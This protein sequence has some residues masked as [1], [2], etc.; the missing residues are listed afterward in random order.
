M[1][2]SQYSISTSSTISEALT[3]T[4]VLPCRGMNSSARAA[5]TS[6]SVR[7]GR[8]SKCSFVKPTELSS[9]QALSVMRSQAISLPRQQAMTSMLGA[10]AMSLAGTRPQL[11]WRIMYPANISLVQVTH[12]KSLFRVP[13]ANAPELWSVIA[14]FAGREIGDAPVALREHHAYGD[15]ENRS[16]VSDA[17]V[18]AVEQGTQPEEGEE[19]L[20]HRDKVHYL[21]CGVVVAGFSRHDRIVHGQAL[22]VR[23]GPLYQPVARIQGLPGFEVRLLIDYFVGI[24]LFIHGQP[25][26]FRIYKALVGRADGHHAALGEES[27]GG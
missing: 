3:V 20:A 7:R 10:Q 1:A 6:S 16:G 14:G 24:R 13:C 2:F 15:R 18:V 22:I 26:V 21:R 11:R 25:A 23:R 12:G 17:H 19:H 8:E 4:G 9:T 5:M 27:V